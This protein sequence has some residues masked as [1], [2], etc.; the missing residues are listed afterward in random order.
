MNNK[1]IHGKR[2]R[3]TASKFNHLRTY[4]SIN[5]KYNTIEYQTLFS[6]VPDVSEFLEQVKSGTIKQREIALPRKI[7][8]SIE[9]ALTE[10]I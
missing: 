10:N 5:A 4:A 9:T 8:V 6:E 3:I 2:K 1:R 7:L